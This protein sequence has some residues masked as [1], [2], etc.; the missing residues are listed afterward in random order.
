V[1]DLY[2]FGFFTPFVDCFQL[3]FII[4]GSG[5]CN[6]GSIVTNSVKYVRFDVSLLL[7]PPVCP[8]NSHP[9]V[10]YSYPKSTEGVL[11]LNVPEF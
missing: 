5:S 3:T 1:S 11:K 6:D 10:S 8:P 7:C 4:S 2:E 9:L